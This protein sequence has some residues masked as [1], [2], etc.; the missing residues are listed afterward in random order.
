MAE[1]FWAP[2]FARLVED[3]EFLDMV[4]NDTAE[5]DLVSWVKPNRA[6]FARCARFIKKNRV[7]D[8]PALAR[9]MLAY[10]RNDA[11]LRKIIL[12]TWVEKNA[13]TMEFPTLAVTEEIESQ[14][15]SG[16]FGS[17]AKV[18][19][20]AKLDPRDGARP[21]YERVLATFSGAPAL[22]DRGAQYFVDT[23]AGNSAADRDE[24]STKLAQRVVELEK[25]LEEFKTDSRQLKKQL[26]ARQEEIK[27]QNRRIEDY[28]RQLKD[29]DA[30][31]QT[32]KNESAGLLSRLKFLE[33]QSVQAQPPSEKAPR[34]DVSEQL[35]AMSEEIAA[36]RRAVDNR[37]TTIRRLEGEKSA[38]IGQQNA[39]SEKDRQVAALRQR[40]AELESSATA[41]TSRLAGHLLSSRREP[42]GR[43]NWLFLSISGRVVFVDGSLVNRTTLVSDEFCLLYFDSAGRP[44]ALESL[45]SDA[46][47]EI[48]GC[49][50]ASGDELF[51]LAD[52]QSFRVQ[53]EIAASLVETPVRG[54]WLP[55]FAERPAGIYRVEA[56]APHSLSANVQKS[57]DSKQI[58]T[59]FR[60]S[61]LNFD[62][63]LELLEQQAI[64]H[65]VRADGSLAF[66]A[67]YREVLEPLRMHVRIPRFCDNPECQTR[68]MAEAMARPSIQGQRCDFC[69]SNSTV[70]VT[71]K[72]QFA[73]QRVLI[74]GGDYVGSEYERV[75]SGYNLNVEWH[76]GFKT[77]AALKSGSGR[78]DLV[79]VIVRQISHTLLRELVTMVARDSLPVLYSSRR[80]ISGVLADLGEYFG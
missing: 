1:D 20:L 47:R 70:T 59:L 13:V 11:A 8:K 43:R 7:L 72:K 71:E 38:L 53:V 73:G 37:E 76:S 30:A 61:H 49:V 41:A 65:S 25:L 69:G 57:A 21:L 51:L 66:S 28:S 36:L 2:V 29:A 78:P 10:A 35:A 40:L 50:E 5:N 74:F 44:L 16:R 52:S 12:F 22:A 9:E 3:Y 19:I 4:A 42:D 6:L 80:G 64:G 39:D 46:R 60:V 33:Q 45:E 75:L 14:L 17:P 79:M 54:I 26:E 67:D 63:F 23:L 55:E 56:L 58:K 31:V 34:V 18:R 24:A 62:R 27:A 68:A 48:C 32:L 77:L 15:Q